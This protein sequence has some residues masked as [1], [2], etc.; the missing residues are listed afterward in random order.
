MNTKKLYIFGASGHGKVVREL[1]ESN[2][3]KVAAF[4]DDNPQKSYCGLTPIFNTTDIINPSTNDAIIIAVGNNYS[5]KEISKRLYNYNFFTSIHK[6]AFVSTSAKIGEGTVI[7][8]NAVINTD[9][10]I[11][12]HVIINSAAVVEHDCVIEDYV[13]ISP[14]AILS[15]NIHVGKGTHIGS[16][17]TVI[18][19][20]K[21]GKWCT[22]GAGTIVLNDVPDGATLIGNPGRIIKYNYAYIEEPAI[23]KIG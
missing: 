19:G 14:G 5:R 6:S 12:N 2:N 17:A 8:V 7:L 16:G 3:H 22:I 9:A 15:G 1:V 23:L 21:I 11:G 13:H 18:P 10:Q 20:V 4:F